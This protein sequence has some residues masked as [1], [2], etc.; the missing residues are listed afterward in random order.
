[1]ADSSYWLA[2]KVDVP[3]AKKTEFNAYVMEILKRFGIRK[4]KEIDVAGGK[5]TILEKP[6]PDE[7]GIIAFD[8]SIFEKQNRTVSK[9]N[10]NTCELYS[11]DRGGNE[12]GL[13]VNCI[14]L[15]QECY[16][17]GSCFFMTKRKPVDVYGYMRLLS[18][19]L[20]RRIYNNGREK[21][22]DMLLLL[23]KNPDADLPSTKDIFQHIFPFDYS[24][25]EDYQLFSVLAADET[26]PPSTDKEPIVSRTQIPQATYI[27]QREYLYRIMAEEYQYDKEMLEAYLNKLL[28]LSLS[29]RK[30]LAEEND[31]LGIL[32]ELS[33]YMPPACLVNAFALLEDSPFWDEWDKFITG[34]YY[35]DI[36]CEDD[37]EE[38]LSEEWE[39]M[40]FYKA[41]FRE[42]EDE[43][44]EFW[45]GENLILSDEMN[46]RIQTWKQ[47]VDMQE[48][49]PELQVKP[50][51]EETIAYMDKEWSCR[52]IDEEFVKKILEHQS[53]SAWRKVLLVLRRIV[54]EGLELFP[55]MNRQ[56]AVLWLKPYRREFDSISIAAYCSLMGN[57]VARHHIF[58]F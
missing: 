13:A 4:R 42:N 58:G 37:K 14:L 19:V 10:M 34:D 50:Y 32:A 20:N 5:I 8:Y 33:L 51:L 40:I 57:D 22:W 12:Y 36:I 15:L 49:Q 38:K 9:Y 46:G 18:T 43:F 30:K 23:K 26:E 53:D 35:T 45:D 6:T 3:E 1:M 55:E 41:I 27:S 56:M 7:N 48:D 21:M 54:D 47:L 17:N 39:K 29:S 16:S 28:R 24:Q 44:L 2:G 25:F 52:Y 11:V 31:N